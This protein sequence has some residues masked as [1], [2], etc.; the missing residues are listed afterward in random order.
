MFPVTGLSNP[1]FVS[2]LEIVQKPGLKEDYL[3]GASTLGDPNTPTVYTGERDTLWRVTYFRGVYTITNTDGYSTPI[4]QMKGTH[5]ISVCFDQYMLPVIAYTMFNG[6]AFLQFFNFANK[7]YET[8]NLSTLA[9]S[10]VISPRVAF[11]DR[12]LEARPF[13]SVVLGY[14]EGEILKLRQ[15]DDLFATAQ[16]LRIETDSEQHYIEQI[17][18]GENNRLHIVTYTRSVP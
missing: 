10:P 1:A 16:I 15:S 5:E 4:L 13:A 12:R 8:I 2:D 3:Y 18:M 14:Y 7:A 9:T 11:D 17:A 6:D